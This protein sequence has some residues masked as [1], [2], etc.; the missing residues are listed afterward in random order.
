MQ[1]K[2]ITEKTSWGKV[3][4]WYGTYLE[5][6]NN[7][8]KDVILPN[9]LRFLSLK[10]HENVLDLACGQG[11]FSREFT[12]T[13]AHVVGSD[14]APEL[15][16]EAE[17]GAHKMNFYVAPASNLLFAKNNQ[18]DT[19]VSVLAVQNI[20]DILLTCT[21]VNR[22]LIP[23]GRFVVVLNHPAFRVLKRSSW[24]FDEKNNTQYRRVD[25]Y[26]SAARVSINMH[27]GSKK[28][29]NTTSYHRSLQ[30]FFK[31]FAGAGFV[32]TRLEE[33][34]SQKKSNAGPRQKA[35]NIA[36]KE[37]LLF[38]AIELRSPKGI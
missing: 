26:L 8:Q 10:E 27:P 6:G 13:G 19:V 22:V 14:I 3:A 2:K 37:I 7:Y 21:E 34:I 1:T 36:R 17:K 29:V 23:G 16:K 9:L 18:F 20:E 24:G 32:V 12:K 28:T 4:E 38:M 11:F 31:A 25:G 15:I 5:R 35:E 30:D 33:W